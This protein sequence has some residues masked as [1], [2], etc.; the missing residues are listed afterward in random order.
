MNNCFA[1]EFKYNQQAMVRDESNHHSYNPKFMIERPRND[2]FSALIKRCNSGQQEA[3]EEL[4]CL[5][6]GDLYRLAERLC[7]GR[8]WEN[9]LHATRLTN[10]TFLRLLKG[11]VFTKNLERSDFFAFA[12]TTMKNLVVDYIR[13]KKSLKRTTDA[14]IPGHFQQVVEHIESQ[15]YDFSDL[16]EA[17]DRLREV[18]PRRAQIVE[19]RFFLKMEVA[20]IAEVINCSVWKIESEWRE[21]RAW[22][23]LQ[24]N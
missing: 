9:S 22:L 17:L 16:Y 13:A 1:P 4:A 8:P 12:A 24:L 20:E 15:P 18:S 6:H 2:E 11:Q 23:F 19:M 21:A 10:E 7:V 14:G 3:R 5:V